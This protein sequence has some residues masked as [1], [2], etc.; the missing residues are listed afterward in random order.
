MK[1][2]EERIPGRAS[3][4]MSYVLVFSLSFIDLG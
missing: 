1:E 2:Q 3:P 4:C